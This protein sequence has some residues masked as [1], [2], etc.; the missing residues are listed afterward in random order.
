MKAAQTIATRT[1]LGEG[2]ELMG[3]PPWSAES[4]YCMKATKATVETATFISD[5]ASSRNIC[6]DLN[7][8]S[9]TK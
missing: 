9:T 6:R 4:S 7:F 2:P 5:N 1:R 8:C 3:K